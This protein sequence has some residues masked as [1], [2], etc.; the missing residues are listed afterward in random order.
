MDIQLSYLLATRNKLPYLKNRLEKLIANL[1]EDEE[2]LVADG[3]S[4][5]GTVEYLQTLKNSGKIS[6]L[7]SEND[8]GIAHALNKIALEAKGVL[9]RFITDDDVFHYPTI[10]LCRDFMFSNPRLDILF[11]NGGIKDQNPS[12][13]IKTLLYHE[14]YKKWLTDKKPFTATDLGV[15][16]RK[17]SIPLIGLWNTS[18]P[19]P[20]AEFVFRVMASKA[21]IAWCNGF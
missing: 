9:I 10:Q 15:M 1:K 3:Q 17:S 4:T 16:F 11:T 12:K 21:E 18:F 2:I 8:V 5:D 7:V 6:Y 13:P 19:S 14:N 20:D